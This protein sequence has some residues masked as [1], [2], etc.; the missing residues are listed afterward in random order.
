MK[1]RLIELWEKHGTKGLL[2]ALV[3]GLILLNILC[4]VVKASPLQPNQPFVL[5]VPQWPGIGL[6]C[7]PVPN[8]PANNYYCKFIPFEPPKKT[9]DQEFHDFSRSPDMWV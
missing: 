9:I 4:G 1:D 3:V 7:Q 6:G 2:V 8:M 5:T